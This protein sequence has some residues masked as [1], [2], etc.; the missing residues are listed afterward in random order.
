MMT[1]RAHE[2]AARL[3]WDGNTG[4]GTAGYAGY[5]RRYRVLVPGKP[6]LQGTADPVFRGEAD[7]HNPED[8]FLAAIS[9]CHML[10]Y[11]A[12]CAR[13]GVRVQLILPGKSDVPLMQAAARSLYRRLLAAG[14]EIYEY[15]PQ[16]LHTKFLLLDDTVFVGSANLDPR[17]FGLNYDLLLRL[18][19]PELAAEARAIFADHLTH[20][21][22]I[23]RSAWRKAR[24]FW[25][26]LKGRFARFLFTRIDP[27][28]TRKQ[29]QGLR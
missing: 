14:V 5:S 28:I 29:I 6:V 27:F 16:I 2:H 10:S 3:I 4:G 21:R 15:Q 9:A 23:E 1:I 26:R 20:C 7:R 22:R 17:S 8:L 13:Q 24:S 25:E 18:P 12:L 19:H 11:L